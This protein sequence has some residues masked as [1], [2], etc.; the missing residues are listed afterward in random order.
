MALPSVQTNFFIATQTVRD[1]MNEDNKGDTKISYCKYLSSIL[2]MVQTLKDDAWNKQDMQSLCDDTSKLLKLTQKC[3]GRVIDIFDE[4]SQKKNEKEISELNNETCETTGGCRVDIPTT[5]PTPTIPH[6][7]TTFTTSLNSTN[8]TIVHELLWSSLP[9]PPGYSSNIRLQNTPNHSMF[10]AYQRRKTL[11]GKNTKQRSDAVSYNLS[12]FRQAAEKMAITQA[13]EKAFKEK[14][15]EQVL[16]LKAEAERR[17]SKLQKRSK[18]DNEFR[19]NLLTEILAF[20]HEVQWAIQFRDAFVLNKE[21]HVA[22][23]A[24][25]KLLLLRKDHPLGKALIKL[26]TSIYNQI[27][28]FVKEDPFVN[29]TF[30]PDTCNQNSTLNIYVTHQAKFQSFLIDDKNNISGSI[31]SSVSSENLSSATKVSNDSNFIDSD[32]ISFLEKEFE[33]LESSMFSDSDEEPTENYCGLNINNLYNQHKVE[34][35]LNDSALN[36]SKI[37]GNEN[38]YL[39]PQKSIDSNDSIETENQYYCVEPENSSIS[40]SFKVNNEKYGGILHKTTSN[41]YE[42][43]DNNQEENIYEEVTSINK[44]SNMDTYEALNPSVIENQAHIY[45]IISTNLNEDNEFSVDDDTAKIFSHIV[46]EILFNIDRL[47]TVILLAYETLDTPLGRDQAYATLESVLFEQLWH[48]VIKLFRK[49]DFK[50]MLKLEYIMK[51]KSEY[52]PEDMMI[53]EKFALSDSSNPPYQEAIKEIKLLSEITSPL[54]KLE[55]AVRTMKCVCTCVEN[56]YSNKGKTP[57]I[58]GCDDLLPIV[59]YIILKSGLHQIVAECHAMLEF[60]HDGYLMGEEG[61]CLTTLQSAISS[62]LALK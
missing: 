8:S 49:V 7:P 10:Q 61:Y 45:E 43:L 17:C 35:S 24:V 14:L 16:R 23:G 15:A 60:I 31:S 36:N 5:P 21:D 11:H 48:W 56:Y 47:Y 59:S 58:L 62:L 46:N 6:T 26:Q 12:L 9:T 39:C 55:C 27:Y 40:A 50:K 38:I 4:Q 3:L 54:E 2:F 28:Q 53:R 34:D 41:T 13:K 29:E 1:A 22:I 30:Q 52:K 33:E 44:F 51:T 20:E 25:L 18:I 57:P 42:V 32:K 37:K 19:Q